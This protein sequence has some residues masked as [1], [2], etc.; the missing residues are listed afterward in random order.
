MW[1]FPATAAVSLACA[2]LWVKSSRQLD[3]TNSILMLSLVWDLLMVTAYYLGPMVFKGEG[4]GW[5]T[6]AAA[7]VTLIGICWFKLSI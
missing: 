2:W 4:L 1:Y 5:Q 7:L 3:D 6:Y